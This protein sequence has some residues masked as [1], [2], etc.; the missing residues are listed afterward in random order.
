MTREE[1]IGD[2]IAS[3]LVAAAA[4]VLGLLLGWVL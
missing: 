3:W 4:G 1:R 2:R